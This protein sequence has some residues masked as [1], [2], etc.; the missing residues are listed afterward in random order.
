MDNCDLDKLSVNGAQLC[1]SFKPDITLYTATVPSSINSVKLDLLTSDSGASC[2]ILFGDGSRTVNLSD[3]LNRIDIEVIAEDGTGKTYSIELT[4]LSASEASLRALA[5]EEHHQLHPVFSPD[6]YEYSCAVSFDCHVVTIQAQ[7]P[8]HNMQV[9]VK[10]ACSSGS[11]PL[12]VGDTLVTVQVTSPDGTNL[13]VYTI[14]IT[15]EHIPFPVTFCDV[16][17]Q[18]MFECPVSLN[19]FYRPVSINQSDPKAIFSSPYI[20][21]LTQRSKVHPFTECPL[22]DSWKVAETELDKRMSS[23]L[24]NCFFAHRGCKSVLKLGEIGAHANDCPYKPPLAL[25]TKDVT[26]TNWYRKHFTSSSSWEI[27]TKHSLQVG[28]RYFSHHS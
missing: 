1:P 5:V 27:E 20:D 3:G 8:D 4:K 23:A 2:K 7:A 18:M 12:N 16:K 22:G 13:Q 14:T 24:V 21:M 11:V 26:E 25:N 15:R 6:L 19:A 9:T 28:Q 17:D 10:E